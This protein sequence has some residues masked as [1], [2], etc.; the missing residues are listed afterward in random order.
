[1]A[2]DEVPLTDGY[3]ALIDRAD[4]DLIAGFNWRAHADPKRADLV[5]ATA[6]HGDLHLLMHRLIVGAGP[7]VAID[8][9]NR[10]SLDNRRINLRRAS[11]QQNGANRGSPR[12]AKSSQYKGVSWNRGH[13]RWIAFIHVDGK[14]RSIGYFKTEIEAAAAYDR[15]AE[16]A[17]GEFAYLNLLPSERIAVLDG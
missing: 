1:M 4:R 13:T 14:S 11:K 2:V 5:Y 10:N 15:A 12:V 3:I 6:W 16:E 9:A 8:H 17:W 7:G